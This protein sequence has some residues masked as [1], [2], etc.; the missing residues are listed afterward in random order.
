MIISDLEILE[1]VEVAN[2]Q[3]GL[4]VNDT[5]TQ[6]DAVNI[7]FSSGNSFGTFVNSPTTLSNSAAAG[8]KGS[9]QN[10]RSFLGF[11]APTY[12]YTKA[13]TLAV[14]DYLGES[15]SASTSVAVIN[16]AS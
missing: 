4:I 11:T 16:E 14:T 9:A 15:F 7:G 8:A 12:S 10:N 3:G 5:Y 2:V 1:V 13:D 6:T